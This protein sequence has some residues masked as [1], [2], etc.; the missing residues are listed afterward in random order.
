MAKDLDRPMSNPERADNAELSVKCPVCG[1]MFGVGYGDDV[2]FV[3]C[4]VC[5]EELNLDEVQK[6][7]ASNE[8][9]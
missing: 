6:L 4:P 8:G 7:N 3:N 5:Q 1:G 2:E 9:Y